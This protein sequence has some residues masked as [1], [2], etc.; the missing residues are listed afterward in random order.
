MEKNTE[1]S[2]LKKGHSMKD[3]HERKEQKYMGEK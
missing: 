2:K 1:F 3:P